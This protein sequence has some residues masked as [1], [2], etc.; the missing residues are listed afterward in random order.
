MMQRTQPSCQ[1]IAAPL[2]CVDHTFLVDTSMFSRIYS[3]ISI[4]WRSVGSVSNLH[5][6]M[7]VSRDHTITFESWRTCSRSSSIRTVNHHILS[8]L[9]EQTHPSISLSPAKAQKWRP[10]QPEERNKRR[11]GRRERVRRLGATTYTSPPTSLPA[12]SMCTKFPYGVPVT[13]NRYSQGQG[14]PRRHP[15][16]SNLR[17]AEQRCPVIP[18]H[19]SRSAGGQIKDQWL[20]CTQGTR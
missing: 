9:Y 8:F 4:L 7:F 15:R 5:E 3:A 10:Q 2:L 20:A 1:L 12:L 18:P 13:D 16:Q 14:Q 17:Q 11:S 19:H 6:I